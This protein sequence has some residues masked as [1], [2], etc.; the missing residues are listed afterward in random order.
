MNPLAHRIPRLLILPL[1]S[2]FLSFAFGCN[3]APDRKMLQS[4]ASASSETAAAVKSDD[5]GIDLQCI[6]GHI[7]KA[8]APF[9][10]SYVKNVSP[11]SNAD[12]EA[13]VSFDSIQGTLVDS[14]GSRPIQGVRA[15]TGSWNTAVLVLTGPLPASTFALVNNSS[16]TMRAGVENVNDETTVKYS[17]DT[18]RDTPADASL[19]KTVLGPNGFVKGSAWVTDKGCPVKFLLDVEQHLHDGSVQKEHYEANVTKR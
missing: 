6:A 10:W 8:L 19:I 12:W 14:S 18:T 3:I 4:S 7:Q 11:F 17:I 15:D 13:D 5:P 1:V 9:H 16:A 2:M